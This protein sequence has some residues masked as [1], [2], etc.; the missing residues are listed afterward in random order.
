M[1]PEAPRSRESSNSKDSSLMESS[2]STQFLISSRKLNGQFLE[3]VRREVES[4]SEKL[5]VK[6]ASDYLREA[7]KL[8][9]KVR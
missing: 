1:G 3:F 9:L 8:K 7:A 6:G 2:R 5:L 4:E